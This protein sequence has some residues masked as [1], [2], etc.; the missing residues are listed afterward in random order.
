MLNGNPLDALARSLRRSVVSFRLPVV[1][2]G[3]P[4]AVRQAA[5]ESQTLFLGY[6]KAQPAKQRAHL[7]ALAF[8]RGTPLSGDHLYLLAGMLSEPLP[9]IGGKR[10]LGHPAFAALSQVYLHE[11]QADHLSLLTW[12][13]LAC[14]YFEFDPLHA[15]PPERDGWEALQRLL[16]RTWPLIDAQAGFEWVPDWVRFLRSDPNLLTEQAADRYAA[17][18]L[19]GDEAGVRRLAIDLGIPQGSWFWHLLVLS[20]V[21]RAIRQPDDRFKALIPRLLA[22]V[23]GRPLHRDQ[24]LECILTRYHQCAQAPLHALLRDYLSR[25]DVW[26]NPELR[27]SDPATPWHRVDE[28]V[29]MMVLQWTHVANLKDFFGTLS[30]RNSAQGR[31]AFWSRYLNQ[32]SW[33][34]LV[35]SPQTTALARR[36]KAIRELIVREEGEYTAFW[37]ARNIDALMMRIG[38]F[39]VVEFSTTGNPAYVYDS[40]KLEFDPHALKNQVGAGGLN[41]GF[42]GAAAMRIVHRAPWEQDA[43]EGL[44]R[45]GIHPDRRGTVP[46]KA[47]VPECAAA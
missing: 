44:K 25:K 8:M 47:A 12:F 46:V 9:E 24:A 27:M 6:A 4:E 37:G 22:L 1:E 45:L 5:L 39:L 19:D 33:T 28:A 32:I 10:P 2:F 42:Q 35:F 31:L 38:E 34:R 29:W 14:S 13:R 36:N 3:C 15:A 18:Y 16:Y 40:R 17:A 30:A 26:R 23:D 20:A 41:Y 11:A 43:E 21:R 7:A